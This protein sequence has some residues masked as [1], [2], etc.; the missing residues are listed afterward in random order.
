MHATSRE[1]PTF[2]H[3]ALRSLNI[4]LL[5]ALVAELHRFPNLAS[6]SHDLFPHL[7]L[8]D[9]AH[10]AHFEH[11]LER[12]CL[13]LTPD[14]ARALPRLTRLAVLK[15]T[16]NDADTT[17]P[18]LRGLKALRSLTLTSSTA[19]VSFVELTSLVQHFLRYCPAI[20]AICTT[21]TALLP[22]PSAIAG[23]VH[24]LDRL[25][26]ERFAFLFGEVGWM[27]MPKNLRTYWVQ[28]VPRGYI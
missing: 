25:G 22:D 11:L 4:P 16:L 27:A 26:V 8:V 1:L 2:L 28:V 19:S 7:P 24:E 21:N 14:V 17:V 3:T 10:L 18:P 15:L 5:P 12:V 20:S 13:T 9:V 6:L 23:F